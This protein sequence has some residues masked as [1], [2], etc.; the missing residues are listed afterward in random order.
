[1]KI[2]TWNILTPGFT[3]WEPRREAIWQ[4]LRRADADFICLQEPMHQQVYETRH[5]P[6][7]ASAFALVGA[8]RE[9]DPHFP[10]GLARLRETDINS[11]AG[12]EWTPI[13]YRRDRYEMIDLP[14]PTTVWYHPDPSRRNVPGTFSPGASFPRIFTWSYFRDRHSKAEL[15]VYNTHLEHTAGSIRQQQAAQLA[16]HVSESMKQ[17]RRAVV[18]G[19]FNDPPDTPTLAEMQ[20]VIPRV[21][22]DRPTWRGF[23]PADQPVKIDYIFA[24]NP[25]KVRFELLEIPRIS[26]PPAK[27]DGRVSDHA[28]LLAEFE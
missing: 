22:D 14:Q 11:P 28:P 21:C 9:H 20:R 25:G 3:A 19:D 12:G 27:T 1:M 8:G 15:F 10:D 7:F 26:P 13:V 5:H 23:G 17:C 4:T 24:I 2:L 18:V 6:D 16:A